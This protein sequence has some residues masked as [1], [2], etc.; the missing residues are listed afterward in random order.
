MPTQLKEKVSFLEDSLNRFI[1]STNKMMYEMTK[2]TRLLKEEM[3]EFKGEMKEFKDE[4]KE[5]REDS[6]KEMKEFK[7][8]MKIS[9]E[10]SAKEMKEFKEEMKE[11][12]ENSAKELK[13]FKEDNKKFKKDSNKQWGDLANKLG[14]IVE[15]IVSPAVR[16]A[17]EKYFGEKVDY[18]AIHVRKKLKRQ[19]IQGEFDVIATTPSYVFLIETKSSP[20]EEY[21]MRFK[22]KNIPHFRKL[23]PEYKK[24]EL[25]PIF[26]SLRFESSFLKIANREK[27]FLLGYRE[28]EYMDI[29]NFDGFDR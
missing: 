1:I 11:H 19:N 8:E 13:E 25:I 2:D 10:N 29:L 9:R 27:I 28:W 7:E 24:L 5:F 14:T 3:K 12:R 6:A 23:F 17:I 15:D 16:P 18:I 20:S 26:A 21:L 22:E 4:M